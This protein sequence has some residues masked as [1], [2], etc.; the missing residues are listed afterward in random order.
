MKYATTIKKVE[1]E[2]LRRASVDGVKRVIYITTRKKIAI[3]ICM[4][5]DDGVKRRIVKT[6]DMLSYANSDGTMLYI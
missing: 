1:K 6:D 2:A 4:D 5:D 3:G